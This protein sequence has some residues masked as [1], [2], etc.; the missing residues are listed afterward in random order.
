MDKA[1]EIGSL[2]FFPFC[3]FLVHLVCVCA[4]ASHCEKVV[5]A[6]IV[7]DHKLCVC[8]RWIVLYF[9][10]YLFCGWRVENLEQ[11]KSTYLERQ[12]L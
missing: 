9:F 6:K 11:I 3:K 4:A 1:E 2:R 12:G 5:N 10:F 8:V 7:I